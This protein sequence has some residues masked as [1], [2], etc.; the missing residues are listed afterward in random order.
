MRLS[1]LQEGLLSALEDG[2]S[3]TKFSELWSR[4]VRGWELRAGAGP[5]SASPETR[6]HAEKRISRKDEVNLDEVVATLPISLHGRLFQGLKTQARLAIRSSCHSEIPIW[7]TT[8]GDEE[9]T[10]AEYKDVALRALRGVA[11]LSSHLIEKVLQQPSK[12]L[13]ETVTE[14][15]DSLLLF[16]ENP[17]VTEA[18]SKLCCKWWLM[19]LPCRESMIPQTWPCILG[20]A[21]A[22]GALVDVKRCASMRAS[23][24][25][26][27]FDDPSIDDLKKMLLFAAFHPGFVQRVEGRRF[28]A[29]LF[30][31]HPQ[32]VRDLTSIIRNQIPAGR[33]NVLKAYGDLIFRGWKGATGACLMEIEETCIQGLMQAAISASTKEMASHL[34][35][36]LNALH[37][38]KKMHMAVDEMLLRLYEPI[39]FRALSVANPAI[40]RNALLL[41]FDAFPLQNPHASH[42]DTDDL[43][44]KQFSYF[45]SALGD[46]A[47][48]VRIAAVEG[49]CKVLDS[50]WELIP[51][52]VSMG[53]L[54]GIIGRLAFDGASVGVRS[55]VLRNLKKLIENPLSRPLLKGLLPQLAPL[56]HDP[57][58]DVRV[59]F[60][61]MLLSIMSISEVHFSDIVSVDVLI[62]MMAKDIQTVSKRIHSLLLPSLF[63]D[64]QQG[65][66]IVA[67]LLR[68]SPSAGLRFCKALAPVSRKC[69][70]RLTA[71]EN[72]NQLQSLP[73]DELLDLTESFRDH[74]LASTPCVMSE[75]TENRSS[76]GRK[77]GTGQTKRKAHATQAESSESVEAWEALICGLAV[78]CDGVA[79]M[80]ENGL[81][82]EE[83]AMLLWPCGTLL[84]LM[85]KAPTAKARCAVM[86]IASTLP[87][88]P[89]CEEMCFHCFEM[90]TGGSDPA[91]T[92]LE[93]EELC[94]ALE[95]VCAGPRNADIMGMLLTSLSTESCADMP[96]SSAMTCAQATRCINSMARN[97]P[98]RCQVMDG[99]FVQEV[100]PLLQSQA[101]SSIRNARTQLT[102]TSNISAST[103]KSAFDAVGAFCRVAMHAST[104]WIV[105]ENN[106]QLNTGGC[107]TA[108]KALP[109]ANSAGGI[110]AVHSTVGLM[111]QELALLLESATTWCQGACSEG[112][113]ESTSHQSKRVKNQE[114]PLGRAVT[115]PV[116][117]ALKHATQLLAFV[118]DA[119]LLGM[120][121]TGSSD[122]QQTLAKICDVCVL[123]L[124]A[125]CEAGQS[126]IFRNATVTKALLL[127][128]C[129]FL[130]TIL[131]LLASDSAD[132]EHFL[133]LHGQAENVALCLMTSL[134]SE[135]APAELAI[136]DLHPHLMQALGELLPLQTQYGIAWLL[137]L[138]DAV[139]N[140][141]VQWDES[142]GANG[143][144]GPHSEHAADT[145]SSPRGSAADCVAQGEP[146]KAGTSGRFEGGADRDAVQQQTTQNGARHPESTV[147]LPLIASAIVNIAVKAK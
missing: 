21:L 84:E 90:V 123:A 121:S 111:A 101:V 33:K 89:G 58:K 110:Q 69:E 146:Q 134:L 116:I 64:L 32:L 124:T 41:L 97:A 65:P 119:A 107:S 112:E 11:L 130:K 55:A 100:L 128:I 8:E 135:N 61:D 63:P 77:R 104:K 17:S 25:L 92:S 137:P 140:G 136:K 142:C 14:M 4:H 24:L 88:A 129:R 13:A 53:Y 23:L 10:P 18:I 47:P 22:S 125:M 50:F 16:C 1:D 62:D 20:K 42:E 7:A 43:L 54:K 56:M 12:D 71:M 139:G 105:S 40:R 66:G 145:E 3:C 75:A 76:H 83:E 78:L 36:V 51:P 9:P 34:R 79:A 70:Q 143:D 19:E 67:M 29:S 30:D 103:H 138:V 132:G 91:H 95:C 86:S 44:A 72:K 106:Q 45:S 57:S 113:E 82:E 35:H 93:G 85:E 126:R 5:A 141:V 15:H 31:L 73:P 28:L 98:M 102:E 37:S 49:I 46:S 117:L 127:H 74:L 39:L 147:Q 6:L 99:D 115:V 68:R 2:G 59:A 114:E 94:A 60:V 122:G 27:D 48:A 80:R 81:C 118:G 108:E 133:P 38:H 120:I 87:M 52:S 109:N 96:A 131:Q 26:F 144:H